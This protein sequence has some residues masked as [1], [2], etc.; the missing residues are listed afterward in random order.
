MLKTKKGLS[1]IIE[2]TIIILLTVIL[3]V[4]VGSFILSW[5]REKLQKTEC[6]NY[7]GYF[8]FSH[9]FPNCYQRNNNIG[10][11]E[12]NIFIKRK[13]NT[14]P[15]IAGFKL[16]F[17]SNNNIETIEVINNTSPT[18][19]ISMKEGLGI[20]LTLPEAGQ[21]KAYSYKSQNLFKSIKVMPITNSRDVCQETDTI[22][23]IL[24]C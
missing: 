13:E 3:I 15:N 19:K 8:S 17:I 20:P 10:Q 18:N 9:S 12:Y 6:S 7:I 23:S 24:Q 22:E 21:T 14:Q 4:F 1:T 2:V 11:Y 5:A 16:V